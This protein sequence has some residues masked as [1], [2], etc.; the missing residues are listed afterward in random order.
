MPFA[1]RSDLRTSL[2]NWLARPSDTLRL[3]DTTLNDMISLA[4]TDFFR[5]LETVEFET[6]DA[7]F[8]VAAE[9]TALPTGFKSFRRNPFIN[10]ASKTEIKEANPTDIRFLAGTALPQVYAIEANQL[11]LGP[12]PDATYVLDITYLAAPAAITDSTTNALFDSNSDLYLFGSLLNSELYV[13]KDQRAA[14]WAERYK[15]SI[16]S[17]TRASNRKKWHSASGEMQAKFA[18]RNPR[19]GRTQCR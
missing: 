2:R 5:K 9:Y 14:L 11:R 17:I 12:T 18:D 6:R 15:A 3:P 16:D 4:E 7:A 1:S 10:A 19:W 8:S 13:G